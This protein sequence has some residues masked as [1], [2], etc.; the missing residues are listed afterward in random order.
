MATATRRETWGQL[1]RYAVNGGLLTI[2]FAIVYWVLVREL[3]RPPQIGTLC[4]YLVAVA[5]G[6][7]LHSRVTFRDHGAR[8]RS[9]QVRFIVASLLSY[10]LNAFWTW[11]CIAALGWPTWTPLLPICIATPIILF[12]INRWWVFR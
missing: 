4:G 7:L 3:R 10:A 11:A 9:T 8:D 12:A 6:Y 2:L 5:A 1:A